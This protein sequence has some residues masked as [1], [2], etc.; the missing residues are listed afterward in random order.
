MSAVCERKRDEYLPPFSVSD[1]VFAIPGMNHYIATKIAL[2]DLEA[3]HP[4]RMQ[5][6]RGSL[7]KESA[8]AAPT[9]C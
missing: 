6:K 4:K 2:L 9:S 8:E 5:P 7:A 3:C 1:T